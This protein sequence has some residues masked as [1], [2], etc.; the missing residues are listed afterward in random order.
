MKE[1]REVLPDRVVAEPELR[2]LR[3][4]DPAGE[5]LTG[6]GVDRPALVPIPAVDKARGDLVAQSAVGFVTLIDAELAVAMCLKP[7]RCQAPT[8]TPIEM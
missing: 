2:L 3:V 5:R 1:L 8:L 7:P 6:D 4:P